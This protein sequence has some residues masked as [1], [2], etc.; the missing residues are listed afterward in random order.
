MRRVPSGLRRPLPEV[1]RPGSGLEAPQESGPHGPHARSG[2]GERAPSTQEARPSPRE[3][4]LHG[5]GAHPSRGHGFPKVALRQAS[6]DHH[7]RVLAIGGQ[8]PV[9]GQPKVLLLEK[10]SMNAALM[11]SRVHIARPRTAPWTPL[12]SSNPLTSSVAQRSRDA[13]LNY[14]R[15]PTLRTT[16]VRTCFSE[17]APLGAG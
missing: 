15:R 7:R 13:S 14:D 16:G 3:E 17:G 11:A 5:Q 2:A 4:P 12:V 1:A 8:S 6:V 10:G 9:H